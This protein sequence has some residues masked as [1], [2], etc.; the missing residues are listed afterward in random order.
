MSQYLSEQTGH[1]PEASACEEMTHA[2]PR[3]GEERRG[4]PHAETMH[5]VRLAMDNFAA[6]LHS[7]DF[8]HELSMLGIP[9]YKFLKRRRIRRE[10]TALT[11]CLWR[12]ALER[13]FPE[14]WRAMFESFL[15]HTLE[16][17]DHTEKAAQFEHTVRN[18]QAM[19]E[20]RR[21][22]DF[23]EAGAHVVDLLKLP[24]PRATSLRLRLTLHIRS[25]YTLVFDR[26]I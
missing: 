23:T 6:L 9:G 2:S 1:Y 4:Q 22:A 26:L 18:Y 19:L 5:D 17:I 12:L 20:K 8:A 14:H 15:A 10:L 7:M 24:E 21:E 3:S 25:L 13:S 16:E 11:I